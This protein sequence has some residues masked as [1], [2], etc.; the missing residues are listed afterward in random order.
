[1]EDNKPNRSKERIE[2]KKDTYKIG[3]TE[4]L[5]SRSAKSQRKRKK[6]KTL[7]A[8][9]YDTIYTENIYMHDHQLLCKKSGGKNTV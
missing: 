8:D 9:K 6:A 1:M 7:K 4:V 3:H 5:H 2:L